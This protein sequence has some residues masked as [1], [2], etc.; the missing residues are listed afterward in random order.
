MT[1]HKTIL[2]AVKNE[3]LYGNKVLPRSAHYLDYGINLIA[4]KKDS[5]GLCSYKS[6]NKETFAE[7]T[8]LLENA[9]PKE[10]S[11]YVM[12]AQGEYVLTEDTEKNPEVQYFYRI[13]EPLNAIT[14]FSDEEVNK[15]PD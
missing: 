11:L 10:L 2:G 15:A 7:L 9:N 3:G 8:D 14:I 1:M 4:L 5:F 12:D 13:V 6:K